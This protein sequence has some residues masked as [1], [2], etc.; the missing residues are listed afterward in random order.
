MCHVHTGSPQ[1][2]VQLGHHWTQSSKFLLRKPR[3]SLIWAFV[4]CLPVKIELWAW[5]GPM[6]ETIPEQTGATSHSLAPDPMWLLKGSHFVLGP[7]DP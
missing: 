4:P 7:S 3:P 1:C 2:I 5:G 6:A